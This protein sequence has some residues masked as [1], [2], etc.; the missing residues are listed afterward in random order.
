MLAQ[1]ALRHGRTSFT[2]AERA[3]VELARYRCFLLGLPEELLPDA[4]RAIVD[5]LSTRRA[6]LR[7]GFDETC[8]A[9]VRATDGGVDAVGVIMHGCLSLLVGLSTNRL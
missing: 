7:K 9:L 1:K 5:I 2:P 3:H 8:S 4:P 6:T